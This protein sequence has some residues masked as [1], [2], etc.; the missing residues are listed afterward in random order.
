MYPASDAAF[1]MPPARMGVRGSGPIQ[2]RVLQGTLSQSGFPY[3]VCPTIAPYLPFD[4]PTLASGSV[5]QQELY[6]HDRSLI[7]TSLCH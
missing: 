3:P 1:D 4:L 6:R 5:S 7:D 2:S